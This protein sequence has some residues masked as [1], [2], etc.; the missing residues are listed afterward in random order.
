MCRQAWSAPS[1]SASKDD[2]CRCC[3]LEV[4]GRSALTPPVMAK[5]ARQA[6]C[7]ALPKSSGPSPVVQPPSMSGSLASVIRPIVRLPQVAPVS[8][9]QRRRRI[10]L[11]RF[12]MEQD[13]R[14]GGTEVPVLPGVSFSVVLAVAEGCRDSL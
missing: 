6:F 1:S 2:A 5:L 11:P 12:W 9:W 13:R 8:G 4:P 14:R 10:E 7:L 3:C